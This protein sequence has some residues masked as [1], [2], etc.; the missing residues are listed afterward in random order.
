[1]GLLLLQTFQS[2][3]PIFV[4]CFFKICVQSVLAALVLSCVKLM[5]SPVAGGHSVVLAARG[6][7]AWAGRVFTQGHQ[8]S[9][10]SLS[11]GALPKCGP[12]CLQSLMLRALLSPGQDLGWRALWAPSS[13]RETPRWNRSRFGVVHRLQCGSA[14]LVWPWLLLYVL[15]W[16]IFCAGSGLLL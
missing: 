14:L 3:A 12:A 16:K 15:V 11:P 10:C 5:G 7:P 9:L 1:M 13:A 8:G 2:Y 4:F 6:S